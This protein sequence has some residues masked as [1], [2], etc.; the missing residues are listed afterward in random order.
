MNLFSQLKMPRSSS[1]KLGVLFL[2]RCQKCKNDK[3]FKTE[4]CANFAQHAQKKIK[5]LLFFYYTLLSQCIEIIWI[6]SS[7]N[8]DMGMELNIKNA[9]SMAENI[10]F[11]ALMWFNSIPLPLFLGELIQIISMHCESKV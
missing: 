7:R 2:S 4:S 3:I 11:C 5:N 10:L 8:K 9:L 1:P 6:S